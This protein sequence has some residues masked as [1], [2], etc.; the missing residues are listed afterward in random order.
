[1]K[2]KKGEAANEINDHLFISST[3]FI[4]IEFR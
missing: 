1:M 2:G 3:T 4:I